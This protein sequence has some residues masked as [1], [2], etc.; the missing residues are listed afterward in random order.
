[1]CMG[2]PGQIVEIIS[3][4]MLLVMVDVAGVRRAVN[5][6]P[7]VDDEHPISTCLGDWVLVHLGF[8]RMRVSENEAKTAMTLLQELSQ[9]QAE[10]DGIP[11]AT[12]P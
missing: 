5:M 2:I 11:M 7:L 12:A 4:D 1:M 10:V 3:P 8:A 6:G 9:L